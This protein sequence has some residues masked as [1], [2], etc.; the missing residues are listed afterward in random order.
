MF[1]NLAAEMARNKMS[2]KTLAI[3]TGITYETLKTRMR[4]TSE[5][6]LVEMQKIKGVFPACSMDY[7][8]ES[9][10]LIGEE[11]QE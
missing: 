2:V 11:D 5:F 3:R 1:P 9:D 8:F 6:R 7:L 4:G 10:G